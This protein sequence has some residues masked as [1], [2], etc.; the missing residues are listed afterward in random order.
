MAHLGETISKQKDRH[1]RCQ[2]EHRYG[3]QLGNET[4]KT[5]TNVQMHVLNKRKRPIN[6]ELPSL[7]WQIEYHTYT[8]ADVMQR[9]RRVGNH[10]TKLTIGTP[11]SRALM[12]LARVEQLGQPKISHLVGEKLVNRPS[13]F[14]GHKRRVQSS[15]P[16]SPALCLPN[17]RPSKRLASSRKESVG[18]PR[19]LARYQPTLVKERKRKERLGS[20][21]VAAGQTKCVGSSRIL[22]RVKKNRKEKGTGDCQG[23]VRDLE[24]ASVHAFYRY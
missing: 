15:R 8:G 1:R 11:D 3:V 16:C 24:S 10:V 23:C 6:F 21:A 17:E 20:K 22:V 4:L 5:S 13:I 18:N 12:C 14:E 9:N 2:A 19:S 7:T